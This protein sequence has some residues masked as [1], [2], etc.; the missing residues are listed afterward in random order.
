[1]L[2]NNSL[3]DEDEDE[4]EEEDDDEDEN[5]DFVNSLLENH[6]KNMFKPC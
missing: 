4:D 2:L 1:M 6:V 5:E 3:T